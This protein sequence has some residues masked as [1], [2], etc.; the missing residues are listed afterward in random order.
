MARYSK[1]YAGE[2]R[3]RQL[4]IQLTP[5][6]RATLKEGAAGNGV[7]L[8][9]YTRELCLRRTTAAPIVAGTYRNPQAR[10]LKAQLTAIG[11]NLNQLARLANQY[12]AMPERD[13]LERATR[14]LKAA[15]SRVLAL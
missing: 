2:R 15:L 7:T 14:L 13:E 6:E 8:S 5:T 1:D 12:R 4:T 9:Q 10:E 3:T 11:N